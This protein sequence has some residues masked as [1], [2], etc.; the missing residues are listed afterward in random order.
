[1]SGFMDEINTYHNIYVNN[2]NVNT[3]P[4][5]PPQDK[6]NDFNVDLKWTSDGALVSRLCEISS[7]WSPFRPL[8]AISWIS[9]MLFL[10]SR[11][12]CKK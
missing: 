4:P 1:M 12:C 9:K 6:S 2:N 11:I 10:D 3:P 5:P 8:K 7:L